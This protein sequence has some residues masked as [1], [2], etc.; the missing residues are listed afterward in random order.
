MK[1]DTVYVLIKYFVM[2]TCFELEE[3]KAHF[4]ISTT[5]GLM[6]ACMD[7]VGFSTSKR[8]KNQI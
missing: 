1:H 5:K 8:V 7:I 6:N 2:Y 4:I 3:I